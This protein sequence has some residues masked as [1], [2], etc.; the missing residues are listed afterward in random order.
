MEAKA[1][2]LLIARR[3]LPPRDQW[4]AHLARHGAADPI[5]RRIL[6][7]QRLESLGAQVMVARADVCNA[8]E[9]RA[10]RAAGETAFGPF[11]AVIHAAG[12]VDD[13]PLLTKTP[14]SVEEGLCAQAARH[15]CAA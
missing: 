4:A 11:K 5:G 14:A 15:P 9:M 13:G 8:E 3:E 7:V 1:K 10:A 12:V 6:A 2:I